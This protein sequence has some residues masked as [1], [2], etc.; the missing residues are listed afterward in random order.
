MPDG[1]A[2]SGRT[3]SCTYTKY[4]YTLLSRKVS[5]LSSMQTDPIDD[6]PDS[7]RSARWSRERRLQF[8]DFRLLWERRINRS[9]LVKFFGI[10]V[11]QASADI[12]MYQNAAPGNTRYNA[13]QKYYVASDAFRPAFP[14]SGAR[15]Y[16]AQ[17]LAIERGILKPQESFLGKTPPM[18]SV[19]IPSRTVDEE[20]LK[21]LVRAVTEV[22][23]LEVEYQSLTREEATRRLISPH[24]FGHDGLRWH[25]RAY[26]HL[27]NKFQ[28]FV[29]GRILNV[30]AITK[31]NVST[32]DDKEWHRELTLVLQPHPSLTAAQR[33][34]IE[35]D[36]GMDN[37]KVGMQCR[38]AML[39]YALPRLGLE[40]DGSPRP[41]HR[42][43]VIA[44][45][46]DIAPF[47]PS[48]PNPG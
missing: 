13:S 6:A 46:A 12:A 25:V 5:I 40:N 28:D 27:R 44:N 29:I 34:G 10:S 15:Q 47:L 37:G 2:P 48:R 23:A 38:Q 35:I 32:M 43:V 33:R 11:P 16:L 7:L 36:Y 3:L 19:P 39:Y 22:S 41:T 21:M 1:T 31:S 9:D 30:G 42:Q 18:G 4:T 24:A 26:C 14:T 8:I 17:L 20:T 45:L